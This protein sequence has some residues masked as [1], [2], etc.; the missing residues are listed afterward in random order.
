MLE[1]HIN[2]LVSPP[3]RFIP[4]EGTEVAQNPAFLEWNIR[5]R[6]TLLCSLLKVVWS[7]S[8]NFHLS[9]QPSA[10]VAQ[11]DDGDNRN[12]NNNNGWR[13]GAPCGGFRGGRRGRG[14]QR[15]NSS[16]FFNRRGPLIELNNGSNLPVVIINASGTSEQKTRSDALTYGLNNNA[17]KDTFSA[18]SKAPTTPRSWVDIE[19]RDQIET[20]AADFNIAVEEARYLVSTIASPNV[21][22]V[23]IQAQSSNNEMP[24][25]NSNAEGIQRHHMVMRAKLGI[26]KPKYPYIGLLAYETPSSLLLA[27]EPQSNMPSLS[28]TALGLVKYNVKFKKEKEHTSRN[29]RSSASSM[30]ITCPI[31]GLFVASGSTHRRATNRARLRAFEDG[32]SESLGSTTSSDFRFPTIVFNHS[33]KFTCNNH[34]FTV[35]HCNSSSITEHSMV[36]DP[37]A[38]FT[39]HT[40]F[41]Q[42]ISRS[43]QLSQ[44]VPSSPAEMRNLRPN[45][46]TPERRRRLAATCST[47]LALPTGN[48]IGEHHDPVLRF[49]EIH[50]DLRDWVLIRCGEVHDLL[51]FLRNDRSG[52]AFSVFVASLAARGE[53]E[54]EEEESKDDDGADEDSDH[55]P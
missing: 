38:S 53:A 55:N 48:P 24:A 22:G 36:D 41:T 34:S 12:N 37:I 14:R 28:G 26:H 46:P 11:H 15:G 21:E 43:L 52:V 51:D 13:G 35:L 1:S 19:P 30:W 54:R 25:F 7:N 33:T 45:T 8:I 50:L 49:P 31:L 40:F 44:G 17:T 16:G 3:P 42:I 2:S 9:I 27:V 5:W 4:G 39:N 20:S 18:S 6:Y 29:N 32:I 23:P 10:N 47:S